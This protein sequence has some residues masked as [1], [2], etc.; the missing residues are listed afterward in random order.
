M[1]KA[2]INQKYP[3]FFCAI[4]IKVVSLQKIIA[5]DKTIAKNKE[6]QI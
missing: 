3:C 1:R 5:K 2:R 4:R 6:N